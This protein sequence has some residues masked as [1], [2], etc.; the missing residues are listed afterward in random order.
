M[1]VLKSLC[2]ILFIYCCIQC[3]LAAYCGGSPNPNAQPNLNPINTQA[4]TL[5]ANVPNGTLYTLGSGPSMISIV[6]VWGSPYQMGYAHGL[7]MKAKAPQF[8]NAVWNYM[9]EEV[10][11]AINGSE[12]WIPYDVAIWIA[13]IGLDVA[14]DLTYDATC[15]YT[16]T[17]IWEEMHGLADA[18]GVDYDTIRRVHMIGELTKGDCSMYGAWGDAVANTTS[19][20]MQLRALDW[21]VTGPFKDFPQVTVYH[22]DP[23]DPSYKKPAQAFANVGFTGWI[24]SITGMSQVQTAISEIGV[25][26]PD[27]SFGEDSRFGIPFTFLLRDILEFDY[28]GDDAINR[29]SSANRTCSLILGVGDAKL[30]MF[31]GVEYSYS[32]AKFFDDLNMEPLNETWHP[33]MKNIVY[34]GMDWLCPGYNHVLNKQL[35]AYYGNISPAISI[36]YITSIVQTGDLHIAVYDLT[37]NQMYV[38]FARASN[39]TV[40]PLYAYDRAFYQLNMTAVFNVQRP[41]LLY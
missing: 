27:A 8:V 33:R 37:N 1:E 40:G 31:R 41:T 20:L 11:Q 32:T 28:T 10:D 23:N 35:A 2:V 34:Y 9:E 12:S 36:K 38:S 4:P 25:A 13:N 15:E 7:L 17:Y 22:P 6:H 19:Q 26:F 21:D 29:I 39:D 24:G 3:S 14:L 16:G 30:P 18:S 5:V